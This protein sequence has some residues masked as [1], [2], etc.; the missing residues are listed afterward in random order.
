MKQKNTFKLILALLAVVLAIMPFFISFNE[1]MT[2]IVERNRFYLWIQDMVVPVQIRMVYLVVNAFG[3]D[4]TAF[5]DGRIIVNDNYARITWNCIGWQ[6]LIL[7]IIT[8]V[9]GL[10]S[11]K[12]TLVSKVETGLIGFIGVYMVNLGRIVFTVLLL[13]ISKPIFKVVF[14]NYLAVLVTTTFLIGFWWFAFRYILE[15]IK[16]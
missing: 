2:N 16:Q 4:F 3:M 15:P 14:H 13:A 9:M 5:P 6:S 11:G 7:F 12:F 1:L 10:R 8:L